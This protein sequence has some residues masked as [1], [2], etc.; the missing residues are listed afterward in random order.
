MLFNINNLDLDLDVD[1]DLDLDSD[2]DEEANPFV[3]VA[4]RCA[5]II[6]NKTSI[7]SRIYFY[8]DMLR[9][10]NDH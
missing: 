4:C 2:L 9:L 8:L 6:S 7:P 3:Y 10:V 5:E 1:L